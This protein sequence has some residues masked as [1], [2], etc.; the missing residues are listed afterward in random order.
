MALQIRNES[1]ENAE[2]NIFGEIGESW[3]SEGITMEGINA[4]LSAITAKNITINVSSLG[5]DVNHAFA[6]HD[7]LK[8][9]N[10]NVTAKIIGMTASAGTVIALGANKVHMSENAL[11]LVHN[12]STFAMGKADDMRAAAEVLDTVDNRLV[13]IYKN[14]TGKKKSEILNLMEEEKWITAEEAKDF[15]F[16]DKIFEPQPIAASIYQSI[17]NTNYLPKIKNQMEDKNVNTE[18]LYNKIIEGVKNL[19]AENKPAEKPEAKEVEIKV[20]DEVT[21][22]I[23]AEIEKVTAKAK[24]NEQALEAANAEIARLKAATTTPAG[25]PNPKDE[26]PKPTNTIWDKIAKDL[27]NR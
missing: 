6:I 26:D 14:K 15:G 10:A 2:I 25:N 7:L 27:K 3:F 17:N 16:V 4:M 21:S 12:A 13:A 5:G 18:T 23:N 19:F 1:S 11:F 24:A 22:F 20:T 8:M 9:K